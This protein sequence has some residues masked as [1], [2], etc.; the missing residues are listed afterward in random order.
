LSNP[1]SVAGLQLLEI[2]EIYW[3]SKAFLAALEICWN[4]VN[5][6]GQEIPVDLYFRYC[7]CDCCCWWK[8][9]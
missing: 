3:S 7:I 1:G 9:A 8:H 4:F 2:I 6:L 5:P